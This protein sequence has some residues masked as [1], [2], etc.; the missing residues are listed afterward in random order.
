MGEKSPKE[1]SGEDEAEDPTEGK[2]K[3]PK[4]ER[5]LHGKESGH[6]LSRVQVKIMETGS[7]LKES[8]NG[9]SKPFSLLVSGLIPLASSYYSVD[10][11]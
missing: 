3:G 2:D 10:H 8:L 7:L 4:E 9:T 11:Q 5:Y 1:A 6:G